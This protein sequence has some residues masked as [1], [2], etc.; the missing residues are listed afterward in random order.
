MKP[1]KHFHY[2]IVV[3]S[4]D[5]LLDAM[6]SSLGIRTSWLFSRTFFSTRQLH[7]PDKSFFFFRG[8]GKGKRRV[9]WQCTICVPPVTDRAE[10]RSFQW[11]S[12]SYFQSIYPCCCILHAY[13]TNSLVNA[14]LFYANFTNM[15]FQKIP[16]P[17]L[18]HTIKHK[19]L[20]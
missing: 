17:H 12:Y 19:F 3:L 18:T 13:Y 15:T 1:Q 20:H 11:T 2:S 10:P 7:L 5:H 6:S 4:W 14:D 8:V 16:F 9:L